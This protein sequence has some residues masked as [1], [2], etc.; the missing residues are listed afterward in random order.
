MV[1]RFRWL[2]P[3]PGEGRPDTQRPTCLP[4]E[5]CHVRVVFSPATLT[6]AVARPEAPF[7]R[8]LEPQKSIPGPDTKEDCPL[9]LKLPQDGDMSD[10]CLPERESLPHIALWNTDNLFSE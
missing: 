9:D 6:R 4:L 7:G 2:R 5:H 8:S 1:S 10:V 3:T